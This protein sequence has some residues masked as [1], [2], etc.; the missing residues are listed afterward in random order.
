MELK[1]FTGLANTLSAETLPEGALVA[2]SNVDIDDAGHIRRRRGTTLID[3]AKYHS[4]FRAD[5]GTVFC[6]KDGNLCRLD[7][8]WNTTQIAAGIGSE[9]L[10][11][12]QVGETVY[13]K[14]S[15][16]ALRFGVTGSAETW[17]VPHVPVFSMA[18]TDGILPA[19]SYQVAVTN[20]R[21]SDGLEG[22]ISEQRDF[23]LSTPGGITVTC[24]TLSGYTANVYLSTAKGETLYRAATGVVGT[25]NISAPQA[26]LGIQLRSAGKY[27]PTGR[28]PLAQSFGRVYIADGCVLWATDPF[29]FEQ[30]DMAS[31]YKLFESRITF[32]ASVTTGV[33]IGTTNG[34]FFMGGEFSTATLRNVSSQGAPE[35][36]PQEID[37]AYVLKGEQ[38]GVGVL[39]MT[40]GGICVG[41]HNGEVINLTN[42]QFEFP[43]ASEVALMYRKQDGLN[44]F[45]GV[46][47]HPGTPTG[48][49]RFGDFVDA[50]IIRHK[51]I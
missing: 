2:A 14:S 4:L 51:E 21:D 10:H 30:V 3:P 38:Q 20:V 27:P 31:G 6:V 46:S 39:F 33:F 8:S 41:T 25:T 44:Q 34:V 11:Y 28:G 42:K 9:K 29:Q 17:G 43:K 23:T 47:S 48:S 5:D 22:G 26:T 19:G 18:R 13:A 50:E 32:T 36:V 1:G 40:D 37:L 12:V 49:A 15:S 35:Q 16:Q 24:P 45:V 7:A